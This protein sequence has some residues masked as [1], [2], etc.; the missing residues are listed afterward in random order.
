MARI[1]WRNARFRWRSGWLRARR[2]RRGSAF[3]FGFRQ[4]D[5]GFSGLPFAALLEEFDALEALEDG[6]FAADAGVGFEAVVF[7]HR[8][9]GV[10]AG[11]GRWVRCALMAMRKYPECAIAMIVASRCGGGHVVT[12]DGTMLSSGAL[13]G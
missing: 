9:N 8:T 1:P 6:A 12:G 2:P 5:R 4:A 11:G 7:G 3:V 10:V 13:S